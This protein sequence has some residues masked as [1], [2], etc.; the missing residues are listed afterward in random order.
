MASSILPGIRR[1][2]VYWVEVLDTKGSEQSMRR[3]WVV[4]STDN[5][6][7]RFPTVIAIPLSSQVHKAGKLP[8]ARILVE[9]AKLVPTA[10]VNPALPFLCALNDSPSLALTEQVRTLAHERL[11]GRKPV[12]TL[13]A[14]A[15]SDID[16][17][18]SYILDLA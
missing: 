4:V 10:H 1:G 8:G 11:V 7:Q 3:P 15:L 17:G 9:A 12:A 14:D 18:L 5:Y 2:D 16:A 13:A 6:H